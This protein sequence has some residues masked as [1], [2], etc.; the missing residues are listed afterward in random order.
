MKPKWEFPLPDPGAPLADF[1]SERFEVLRIERSED[2]PSRDRAAIDVALLDM[3]HGYPNVGH[4]AIVALL[5]DASLELGARLER[6]G[7]RVRVLSYAVRD[8]LALPEHGDRRHRLYVGTGGPGHLDPHQNSSD[9]GTQ[10]IV[11]DP[12]WEARLWELFD[13]VAADEDAAL[14]GV[15]HTFGLVCRWRDIAAPVLRGPEKGG[16]KRGV[17]T[18]VLTP[19]A[20]AHPWFGK[21]AGG[22][23]DPRLV[24]VLD[25]RYYDL[26]PTHA[27]LPEGVVPIAF[28]S[29]G[30]NGAGGDALTMVEIARRGD[31]TPRFFA[32]NSHPEIGTPERVAELLE[33]MLRNGTITREV[34][35]ERSEL[36]PVLRQDRNQERQRVARVVFGDLVRDSLERLIA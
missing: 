18:N 3:N 13:A 36:L 11:E 8:K 32:V 10:E 35:Q 29:A 14:F 15:C 9:R 19:Q 22:V 28:E 16:P 23:P 6:T 25:S 21:L 5:R 2:L 24:P 4:D 30:S 20:L 12:S 1:R 34:Y 31:G 33:R 7:M 27:G 26:V 17:G